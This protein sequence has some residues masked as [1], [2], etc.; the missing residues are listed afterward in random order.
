MADDHNTTSCSLVQQVMI[1]VSSLQ[2]GVS[3]ITTTNKYGRGRVF[4]NFF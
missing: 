3:G 2:I 1:H 4:F